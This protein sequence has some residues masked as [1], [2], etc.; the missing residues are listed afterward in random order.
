[1]EPLEISARTVEEAIQIA[2]EELGASREEVKVDV[3]DEGKSGILGLGSGQATVRVERISEEPM[4]G[5]SFSDEDIFEIAQDVL[6]RLLELLEIDAHVL[7]GKPVFACLG[8]HHTDERRGSVQGG[9]EED[10]LKP[11]ESPILPVR[12]FTGPAHEGEQ[13]LCRIAVH[14]LTRF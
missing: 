11:A 5:N 7:L 3:L 2:L 13:A 4:P 1:M 8:L 14:T 12:L 10:V 9:E 6:D